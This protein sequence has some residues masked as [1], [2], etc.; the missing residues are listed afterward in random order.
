M[1][2][3]GYNIRGPAFVCSLTRTRLRRGREVTRLRKVYGG[4]ANAV[5]RWGNNINNPGDIVAGQ[6]FGYDYEPIRLRQTTA[7][8]VGKTVLNAYD[9][10]AYTATNQFAYLYDGWNLI[11]ESSV[12]GLQSLTTS[13]ASTSPVPFRASAASAACLHVTP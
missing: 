5:R 13:G 8:Q 7:G 2:I 3:Y 6:T 4:Q 9:N 11:Q 1:N 12:F 10:G